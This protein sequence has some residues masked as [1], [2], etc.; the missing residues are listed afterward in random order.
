MRFST[1]ESKAKITVILEQSNEAVVAILG[2]NDFFA[3]GCLAGQ[4]RIATAVT[5]TESVVV[6]A[7]KSQHSSRAPSGT[8]VRQD[9]YCRSSGRTIRIEADLVDQLFN[10]I[11][12]RLHSL[13]R[14]I[15]VHSSLLNVV[16]HDAHIEA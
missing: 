3:E 4:A 16:L 7:A 6:T 2:A 14:H 13:Q 1:S 12:N 15:E 8:S 9:V 5:M 10:S 11:D